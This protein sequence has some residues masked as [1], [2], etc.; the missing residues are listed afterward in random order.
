ME[1]MKIIILCLPEE[2]LGSSSLWSLAKFSIIKWSCLINT[3]SKMLSVAILNILFW[4]WC[5][6]LVAEESMERMER[7]TD[8]T[9]RAALHSRMI[10]DKDSIE[11]KRY[12]WFF[13]IIENRQANESIWID[14]LMI[15]N[16]PNKDDLK[17]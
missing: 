1:I 7:Q 15:R 6:F 11:K 9:V 8:E 12:F 4:N 3:Y 10:L 2:S 16:L 13:T 5:T 17:W 14:M